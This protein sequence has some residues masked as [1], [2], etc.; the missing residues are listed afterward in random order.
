[1]SLIMVR[2][3]AGYQTCLRYF[4]SHEF[5][6]YEPL[7]GIFSFIFLFQIAKFLWRQVCCEKFSPE[8]VH[9]AQLYFLSD[10]SA[11]SSRQNSL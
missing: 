9:R 10:I 2:L 5:T 8:N 3:Y 11:L 1:M 4:V 6:K 7:C